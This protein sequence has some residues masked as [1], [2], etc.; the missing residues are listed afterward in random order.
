[1]QIH[2][3][4]KVLKTIL[5][6]DLIILYPESLIVDFTRNLLKLTENFSIKKILLFIFK[7]L[8]SFDYSLI[9]Q[10]NEFN[11]IAQISKLR[12]KHKKSKF[13]LKFHSLK[14]LDLKNGDKMTDVLIKKVYELLNIEKVIVI[15]LK[16]LN[17]F[18]SNLIEL[19][20]PLDQ[21]EIELLFQILLFLY[22][23]YNIS[24][25]QYPKPKIYHPMVQL[26]FRLFGFNLNL[27]KISHWAIPKFF[28]NLK[29]KYLGLKSKILVIF[30]NKSSK[31]DSNEKEVKLK[32][33]IQN[34][35]LMEF[36]NRKLVKIVPVKKELIFNKKDSILL[37]Q[38]RNELS[39][40]YGFVSTV[41]KIDITLIRFLLKDF[42]FDLNKINI[43][44]KIKTLK[45]L[46]DTGYFELYPEYP[47]IRY[48]KTA[49]IFSFIKV[50]LSIFIDLH[51]F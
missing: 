15:N 12:D 30:T 35:V 22:R 49:R 47:V 31:D 13:N 24:W 9:I 23:K 44:T 17:K 5:F 25:D 41:V 50:M 39:R 10:S 4:L 11:L 14:D 36:E 40:S 3:L 26:L 46:R 38:I 33:I 43:V 42:F 16:D 37:N 1:M 34:P 29:N 32:S 6:E 45:M 51:M 2:A 27:R 7:I 20:F 8:P 28:L 48:L 18:I 21:S 19:N